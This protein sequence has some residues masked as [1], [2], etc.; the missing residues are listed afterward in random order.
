M[1]KNKKSKNY[2]I[3]LYNL[4]GYYATGGNFG[5]KVGDTFKLLGDSALSTVGLT[6]VI[7]DNAYRN[8]SF[9]DASRVGESI[10]MGAGKIGANLLLPGI[11]G[12]GINTLQ[13]TLGT[14][15]GTDDERARVEKLRA[16]PELIGKYAGS[17]RQMNN[18]IN[19][20]VAGT[21]IAGNLGAAGAANYNS[22]SNVLGN[23][24]DMF[25]TKMANGGPITLPEQ[26]IPGS[27]RHKELIEMEKRNQFVEEQ[28]QRYAPLTAK[29]GEPKSMSLSQFAKS[30]PWADISAL[31]NDVDTIYSYDRPPAEDI[32]DLS[33]TT[34]PRY[35]VFSDPQRAGRDY[36][37]GTSAVD[38]PEYEVFDP[39]AEVD[40]SIQEE[41]TYN[42]IKASVMR[43]GSGNPVTTN[44]GYTYG[45]QSDPSSLQFEAGSPYSDAVSKIGASDKV[46]T[47]DPNIQPLV[48]Q[49]LQGQ[50]A[51]SNYNSP[52][53]FAYGGVM[54]G[55]ADGGRFLEY[56]GPTHENG[57]IDVDANGMP[58]AVAN[59]EG[60][61]TMHDNGVENYIFSDRLIVD[62]E[63]K[64]TFSDESK[65][66]NKK[67]KDATD[68]ISIDSKNMELEALKMKQENLKSMMAPDDS[69]SQGLPMFRTGG[70]LDPVTEKYYNA[71]NDSLSGLNPNLQ[72][73]FMEPPNNI[74]I[75]EPIGDTTSEIDMSI[76][77]EDIYKLRDT[78][79]E[80]PSDM[81]PQD[82]INPLGYLSSNIGN[83][84]DLYEAGQ[85]TEPNDFGRMDPRTIN[86]EAQRDELRNQAAISR[87]VGRE[88]ARS[89]S[90]SGAAF[91]NQVISNALINSALGSGLSES[92]M[93]EA[94][95][96][97]QILNQAEQI[98]HQTRIQEN[99]ADQQ[100]LANRKSTISRALHNIGM[101]TQGYMRDLESARVGNVN[102]QMWF[103]AI[104]SGKYLD[105]A[106]DKD[107]NT[108]ILKTK[109][110]RIWAKD[111]KTEEITEVKEVDETK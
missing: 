6:D 2:T 54:N 7:G 36:F 82:T 49:Y 102:N 3:P 88:N 56:E 4:G 101:N 83:I 13:S 29:Y 53:T 43:G 25:K 58:T 44:I 40:L 93:T 98:N 55:Y 57:G 21:N 78:T 74:S 23:L 32:I 67:Y 106:F 94:N 24:P 41:K 38:V 8:Q 72:N 60:G 111:N 73:T 70:G 11:G 66:I 76:L 18:A 34:D 15:D 19:P 100:D 91:T 103:D 28:K 30:N 5:S 64:T 46:S 79:T 80:L 35:G 90:S 95:Q 89:A 63:K 48:D 39:T 65:K 85:E 52:I 9:A 105:L 109:D 69:N 14:L 96:N 61:E 107:T 97:A 51:R 87:A 77:P 42:P 45:F 59:V 50:A 33:Y 26:V 16:N 1:A 92:F 68:K 17:V 108:T 84:Y 27:A 110:G 37:T 22:T 75:D 71:I 104:K 99:L 20:L 12:A 86:L 62:P 31:P 47:F 81:L 10:G